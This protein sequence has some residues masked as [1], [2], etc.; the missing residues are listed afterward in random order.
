MDIHT[1]IVNNH[2]T[3]IVR[4]LIGIKFSATQAR[5]FMHAGVEMSL[6]AV[7]CY[8]LTRLLSLWDAQQIPALLP[9]IALPELAKSVGDDSELTKDGLRILLP[10]II[11][12]LGHDRS[13]TGSLG[14]QDGTLR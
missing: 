4:E 14:A 6:H 7:K 1:S 2:G 10:R 9:F 3:E 11:G 12:F 8:G 13:L 5:S